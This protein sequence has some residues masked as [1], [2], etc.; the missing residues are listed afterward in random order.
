MTRS[1][2]YECRRALACLALFGAALAPARAFAQASCGPETRVPFAG[3]NFPVDPAPVLVDA[4]PFLRFSSP[5]FVTSI[6]GDADRLAVIE[7]GGRA[8][9]FPNDRYSF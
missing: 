5:L 3:H 7:Q 6:P 1:T 4:F 2:P 8:L 9:V